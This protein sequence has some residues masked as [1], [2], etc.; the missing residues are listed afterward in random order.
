MCVMFLAAADI[1]VLEGFCRGDTCAKR[2]LQLWIQ[3][4]AMKSPS[5][6]GTLDF[7]LYEQSKLYDIRVMFWILLPSIRRQLICAF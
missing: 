7:N 2:D 3:E 6:D 1:P 5:S 4:V